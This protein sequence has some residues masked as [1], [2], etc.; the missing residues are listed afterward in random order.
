MEVVSGCEYHHD[1]AEGEDGLHAPCLPIIYVGSQLVGAAASGC[2]AVG[3][4]LRSNQ[5]QEEGEPLQISP[6]VSHQTH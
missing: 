4:N 5:Y 1:Q 3:I 2:E 6:L